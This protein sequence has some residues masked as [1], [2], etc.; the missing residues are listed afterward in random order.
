MHRARASVPPEAIRIEDEVWQEA[1]TERPRGRRRLRSLEGGRSSDRTSVAVGR[2]STGSVA[3]RISG[4]A[5]PYR[6]EPPRPQ[7]SPSAPE[8][9]TWTDPPADSAGQPG[10]RTITITGRGAERNVPWHTQASRRRSTRRVHER[11]GF[12]PDRFAMWALFLGL[13]LLLVAA[14]SAHA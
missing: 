8:P 11:S 13:L 1:F 12:R 6:A 2:P 7:T 9:A 14:T 5:V 4:P 3:R 10:R